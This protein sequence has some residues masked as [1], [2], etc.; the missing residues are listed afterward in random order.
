MIAGVAAEARSPTVL[1]NARPSGRASFE[2]NSAGIVQNI[3]MPHQAATEEK[4]KPVN[5]HSGASVLPTSNHPA[6]PTASAANV[7]QTRSWALSELRLQSMS[8]MIATVGGMLVT[9]A[10]CEIEYFVFGDQRHP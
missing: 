8:A 3:P 7:C 4:I 6:T 10:T 2:S 1:M 5:F 9:N